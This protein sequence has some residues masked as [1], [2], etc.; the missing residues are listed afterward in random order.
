MT[1]GTV[2]VL[3]ADRYLAGQDCIWHNNQFI[4]RSGFE[5]EGGCTA[6]KWHCSIKASGGWRR[7][8]A[9][10]RCRCLPRLSLRKCSHALHGPT[11]W[12]RKSWS[13]TRSALTPS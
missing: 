2:C 9:G 3:P 11:A 5:R 4:S 8:G 12:R 10:L 7:A 6:N 1:R 13:T